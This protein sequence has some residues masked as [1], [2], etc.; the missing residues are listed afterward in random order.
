MVLGGSGHGG[1]N[2]LKVQCSSAY[3]TP[4]GALSK[5]LQ[6]ALS[7]RRSALAGGAR[8]ARG[9]APLR[10]PPRKADMCHVPRSSER[11]LFPE[12]GFR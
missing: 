8:G 9:R 11:A 5:T 3:N 7:A 2:L 1:Y 12:D 10:R 4:T 6:P